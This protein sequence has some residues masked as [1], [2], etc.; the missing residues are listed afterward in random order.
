MKKYNI[1]LIGTGMIAKSHFD[2][3]DALEN[4]KCVAVADINRAA[5]EK[6]AKRMNCEFFTDARAMLERVPEI[7]VCILLLPTF[8]HAEYVELCA[9]FRKATICEKPLEMTVKNAERIKRAVAESGIKYM[10]AQVVRFW[11]G[12]VEIKRMMEDG[13]FGDIYMA[14]F[15]RCSERQY[16]G[17]DWLFDPQR[18]GGAMHD[19]MVH[20]IDYMNHLFGPA[21]SVYTLAAKDDT[22][23][24]NNVFASLTYKNGVHAVAET[25]FN[26]SQGFPFTMAAKIVGSKATVDFFYSAGFDINQR[27]SSRCELRVYR[28]G[29][30]PEIRVPEQYDPYA[31]EIAYFLDCL[32]KD[33]MPE[34]VTVDESVEVIKTIEAIEKSAVTETM[35]NLQ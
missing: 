23:C 4:A 1:A 25:S 33:K 24:Y 14:N 19:M 22:G 15:S 30:E 7:D 10:T 17:N 26:M 9:E 3:I 34:R 13:E 11:T 35:V 16:W 32:D 20:D 31:K 28:K 8:V 2:A 6:A 12:Y 5:A 29:H 27:G 18:G 21:K